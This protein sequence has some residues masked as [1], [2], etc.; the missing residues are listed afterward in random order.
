MRHSRS[1]TLIV[2][3]SCRCWIKYESFNFQREP[4]D[5]EPH[6]RWCG[7]TGAARLPPTRCAPGRAHSF[8]GE[9]PLRTRQGESL[10]ERQGC[11]SRGGIRRKPQA[12]RWPDEQKPH[13]RRQGWMRRQR[14]SKS[15]TCTESLDVYAA[16][17]SV[18]VG[19]QYPGR[20]VILPRASV[21]ERWRDEMA[22]VSRRHSRSGDQTEGPNT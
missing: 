13:K 8:E 2:W 22:E 4:P 10:A 5:A 9:S 6:V 7:R 20:S 14:S 11:P 19:A 17:I 18:K 12:K 16:G 21:T 3:V 1:H 15:D